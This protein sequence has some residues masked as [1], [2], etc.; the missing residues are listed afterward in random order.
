VDG[1]IWTARAASGQPI[2]EGAG[3]RVLFIEGVKLI[4][5]PLTP[6]AEP[7]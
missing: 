1:K 5:E 3:V 7:Q 4:V 2:E 6:G